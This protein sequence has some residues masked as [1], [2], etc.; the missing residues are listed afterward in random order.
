MF[1]IGIDIGYGYT[2]GSV[3]SQVLS[4][5][6]FPSLISKLTH[7][8]VGDLFGSMEGWDNL[9]V[10]LSGS[11][12]GN[13]AVGELAMLE[14][15]AATLSFDQNKTGQIGTAVLLAT[16]CAALSSTNMELALVSG[17][18]LD[19]YQAQKG[20]F[21]EYL[22]GFNAR[23]EFLSGP[24]RGFGRTVKFGK[25]GVLPQSA[26]AYFHIIAQQRAVPRGL[27]VVI[28]VGFKTTDILVMNG[29][30]PVEELSGT[31]EIGTNTV[32][33][34]VSKD[35]VAQL[36][37]KPPVEMCEAAVRTGRVF[38]RGQE[39]NLNG[40]LAEAKTAMAKKLAASLKVRLGSSL[41][42]S[43]KAHEIYLVG[44][45]AEILR[46]EFAYLG[47]R[48]I[49]GAQLANAR[50]FLEQASNL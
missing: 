44:G 25:V 10:G 14:G 2:K 31:E 50:G 12:D 20:E 18:P 48:V 21:L 8:N 47:G 3:K 38:F 37:V 11:V 30:M 23:V 22:R 9:R 15:H 32:A 41:E 33:Q 6:V 1:P 13:Y 46:D 24:R 28:D 40:T 17:L 49:E 19:Y 29:V 5:L 26:G 16:M 7:R 39:I 45:G 4:D 42:F 36:G 27:A 35:L 43:S 34:A